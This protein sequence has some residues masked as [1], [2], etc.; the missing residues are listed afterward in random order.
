[1]NCAFKGFFDNPDEAEAAYYALRDKELVNDLETSDLTRQHFTDMAPQLAYATEGNTML[2]NPTTSSSLVF[3]TL[4][5]SDPRVAMT[6]FLDE[7]KEAS[8]SDAYYL[9]GHC[10]KKDIE[11]VSSCLKRCGAYSV[12]SS[13]IERPS[14]LHH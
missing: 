11:A 2:I 7:K 6:P 14:R 5:S 13:Q 8:S 3:G 9:Y 12:I 1:M 4:G 10:R